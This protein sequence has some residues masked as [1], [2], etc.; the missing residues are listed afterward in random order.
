MPKMGESTVE[1]Q[2]YS[3]AQFE[4]RDNDSKVKSFE[5]KDL[6]KSAPKVSEEH[7][8]V[9]KIERQLA[10]EKQ[11]QIAPIVEEFRGMSAQAARE[12]E[13]RIAEEVEKRIALI[14]E[15]AYQAGREQGIEQGREEILQQMS[16]EVEEKIAYF[17][18]MIHEVL[19][20]KTEIIERQKRE[21]FVMMRNLVK[22]IILRELK[23]DGQYINRLLEKLVVEIGSK[24]HL[25]IQVDEKSFEAM[26]EV[27]E[28]LQRKLG[29]LTNVRVE[30]DYSMDRPGIILDSQNG[31][32]NASLDQQFANL[33]KLFESV[34]VAVNK[35][36]GEGSDE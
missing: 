9:I 5:F 24:E 29:E 16:V 22:W 10:H 36:V 25:L 18:E 6:K 15:E 31:I 23:E 27:L 30:I 13:I 12:R 28:I 4:Q 19:A 33:D 7:E 21:I 34:G 11:F 20:M 3:F 35:E 17:T 26:P 1:V 2:E 32:I 14:K 8:R